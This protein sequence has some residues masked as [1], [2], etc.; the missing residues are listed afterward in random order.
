[1]RNLL[2]FVDELNIKHERKCVRLCVWEWARE[3]ENGKD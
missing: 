1:M 3:R 2:D